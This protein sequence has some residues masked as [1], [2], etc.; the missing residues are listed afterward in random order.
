[1]VSVDNVLTNVY[2]FSKIR[3]L[4]IIHERHKLMNKQEKTINDRIKVTINEHNLGMVRIARENLVT[5][6]IDSVALT[7][8][9]LRAVVEFVE[10][11][12]KAA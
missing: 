5:A 12:E 4:S 7:Q 10:A 2:T 6:K 8:A 9:D 1:M 3:V 11:Q